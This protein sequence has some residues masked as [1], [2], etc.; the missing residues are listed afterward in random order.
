[1]QYAATPALWTVSNLCSVS[2]RVFDN[3]D[4]RL[5]FH[6]GSRVAKLA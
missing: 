4:N 6:L 1:M 5:G 2:G 3:D